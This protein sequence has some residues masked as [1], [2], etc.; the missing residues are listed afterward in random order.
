MT[1]HR[2]WM[3][4]I[5]ENNGDSSYTSLQEVIL[6]ATP[7]GA[8]GA[9]GGAAFASSFNSSYPPG[10]A[11]DGGT[12]F[13]MCF[14]YEA[15]P[16]F[17]AYDMGEGNAL[18]VAEIR[19]VWNSSAGDYSAPKHFALLHSD[20]KARWTFVRGWANESFQ[21]GVEKVYDATPILPNQVF[22][23]SLPE[24]M[25]RNVASNHNLPWAKRVFEAGLIGNAIEHHT[26]PAVKTPMTGG[27]FI[28]GTTTSLGEPIARR[29]DLVD[30]RSGQLARQ[31]FTGPDGA[32]LFDYIGPGPW[33]VIGV[34]VS[35][36]Q[37]S[38]IYAHVTPSPMT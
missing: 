16:C 8:Q 5:S 25:R 34:D 38:V 7:G 31:A 29:V 6:A 27:H 35:A 28:Q 37:N 26:R 9:T 17:I 4:F 22:N 2:F 10:N 18:D 14:R 24:V 36:E 33:S 30:Q 11:F 23:R 3:V 19:L 12:A 15:K 20:D 21:T 1:A 32:F 13:W